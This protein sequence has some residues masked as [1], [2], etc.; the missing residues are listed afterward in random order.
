[1]G[2]RVF[3]AVKTKSAR[4]SWF[5]RGGSGSWEIEFSDFEMVVEV[6]GDVIV[7]ETGCGGKGLSIVEGSI[8]PRI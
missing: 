2:D 1:M 4:L 6:E 7:G 5:E 3:S 8:G